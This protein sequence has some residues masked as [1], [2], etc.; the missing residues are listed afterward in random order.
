MFCNP[1]SLAFLTPNSCLVTLEKPSL[2]FSLS[3]CQSPHPYLLPDGP[4]SFSTSKKYCNLLPAKNQRM[5]AHPCQT[6]EELEL[7]HFSKENKY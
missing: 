5:L 6:E 1:H 4:M 7:Y 3:L 2:V